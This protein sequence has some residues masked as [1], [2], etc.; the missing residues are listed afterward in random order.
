MCLTDKRSEFR[1][2]KESLYI[3]SKI[4]KATSRKW[5]KDTKR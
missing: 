5:T 2:Y 1:L 4:W 3:D